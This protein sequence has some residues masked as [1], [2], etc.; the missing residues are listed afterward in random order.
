MT[1]TLKNCNQKYFHQWRISRQ[2][3]NKDN[4]CNQRRNIEPQGRKAFERLGK[5]EI[6]SH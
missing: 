4:E 6:D 3:K 2:I 1:F 5:F